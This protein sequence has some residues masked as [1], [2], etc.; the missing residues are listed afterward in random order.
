MKKKQNSIVT[1]SFILFLR[2]SHHLF[3][4]LLHKKNNKTKSF[5]TER[6]L[7]L[8]LGCEK[9][10]IQ[11]KPVHFSSSSVFDHLFLHILHLF[12]LRFWH[13]ITLFSINLS[14][15]YRIITSIINYTNP[16]QSK[17]HNISWNSFPVVLSR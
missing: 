1:C 4:H 17:L 6:L 8:L 14:A 15:C 12:F 7:L 2:L 10:K 3:L 5:R 13:K 16:D 11:L 9:N